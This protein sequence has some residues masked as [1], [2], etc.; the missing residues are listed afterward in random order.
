[1]RLKSLNECRLIIGSYPPFYY[2]ARGGGGHATV[3]STA[4][5]NLL[6]LNFE[7]ETFAIPPLTSQ[8]TRFLYFPLPPGLRIEMYM[9][10]LQGSLNKN[11]GEVL[12]KFDSK[13]IFSINN[14]YKFPELIVKT[15]L[16]TGDVK[17]K[18][19]KAKGL[20]LQSNG[21]VSLVGVALIPK[22]GNFFL[23]KFLNLP[24]EALAVLKCEIK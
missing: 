6:Q 8:T 23:D 5:N 21:I 20:P 3:K 15:Y 12:L 13:F 17:G 1:M 10:E 7:P 16:S 18:R 4:K 22:T 24:N 11:N 2:D 9:E 19:H 14:L